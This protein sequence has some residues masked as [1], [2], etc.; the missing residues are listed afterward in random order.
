MLAASG[1][2]LPHRDRLLDERLDLLG[3][4]AARARAL[5]DQRGARPPSALSVSLPSS[6]PPLNSHVRFNTFAAR[7]IFN[8][9]YYCSCARPSPSA[10]VWSKG[11][12]NLS[13][14]AAA[15]CRPLPP[16]RRARPAPSRA[17]PQHEEPLA[18]P[19]RRG[20]RRRRSP[21]GLFQTMHL[22]A[23]AAAAAALLLPLLRCCCCC[24]HSR[25][26]AA[27]LGAPLFAPAVMPAG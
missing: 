4:L 7:R 25:T 21:R 27:A 11:E 18:P 20:S 17:A 8:T 3:D 12:L 23:V 16:P 2:L 26:A 22:L 9:N 14:L 13:E 10:A 6:C 19:H 15:F 24:S 5:A 1:Q